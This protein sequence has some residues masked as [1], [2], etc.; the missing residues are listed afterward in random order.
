M[1]TD[2]AA[3]CVKHPERKAYC[4]DL[5]K[6][7]YDCAWIKARRP[8]V[9]ELRRGRDREKTKANS[10]RFYIKHRARLIEKQRAYREANP[11]IIA[12]KKRLYRLKYGDNIK[13]RKLAAYYR[14]SREE[15]VAILEIKS[16]E[17]CGSST[18]LCIDH[19]HGTGAIRGRL[20]E[21]CNYGLGKFK[22]SAARLMAA[23]KYLTR[24]EAGEQCA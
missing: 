24:A 5:C 18:R 14:V 12:E 13:I 11:D 16:C 15:I 21:S 4:R 1:P 20:C 17:I 2:S 22:D 19:D 6:S 10:R 9:N 3:S 7:C 23:A 8:K